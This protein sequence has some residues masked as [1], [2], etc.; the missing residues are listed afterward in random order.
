MTGRI[1]Q[2]H[3]VFSQRGFAPHGEI[4]TSKN[5]FSFSGP[6]IAQKYLATMLETLHAGA[7]V[8]G[9]YPIR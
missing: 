6:A 9:D 3:P 8:P 5:P 7:E 2:E 4:I 1:K